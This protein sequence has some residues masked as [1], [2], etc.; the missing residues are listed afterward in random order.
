MRESVSIFHVR[1][2][3]HNKDEAEAELYFH[4]YFKA[5]AET[6]TK[7]WAAEC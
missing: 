2:K 6:G 3:L 7:V 4:G 1:R 5:L